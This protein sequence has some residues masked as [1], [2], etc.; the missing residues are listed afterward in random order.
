MNASSIDWDIESWDALNR[1]T[2]KE[3]M[4]FV[5]ID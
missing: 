1:S 3:V 5:L 2:K 4:S